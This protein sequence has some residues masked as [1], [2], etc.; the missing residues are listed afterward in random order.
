[1]AANVSPPIGDATARPWQECRVGPM[2][3]HDLG[4]ENTRMRLRALLITLASVATAPAIAAE[5]VAMAAHRAVYQLS[6]EN[7]RGDVT[8]AGGQM[9]YE[10]TDACDGWATRQRLAMNIT[11]RDGQQIE[12]ISDYATWEAKDGLSMRFRMRQTTDTAVTEQV[13][14]TAE[15]DGKGGPGMVHYTVPEKKDVALPKG[16]LFSMAH[17]EAII[18]AA[19]SG[20]KFLAVPIFDGT[21][22][23]GAQ[24]SFIVIGSWGPSASAPYPSLAKLDSGKVNIS[25][26][27]RDPKPSK[28]KPTGSPDYE[29][30]MTYYANG[31]ANDL[32]MNFSDFTMRGKFAE[33]TETPP[34][35]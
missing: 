24:D 21:G 31:V 6:L 11:S 34:H 15:L 7:S 29:V 30:G 3:V 12:L 33:F 16:T 1:M 17:T 10:V 13:E 35:C 20:Q 5:P 27:D 9:K 2:S 23:K 22:D 25:F 28:D 14:G 8:D 32:M 4:L 26:F 19:Q 18:A